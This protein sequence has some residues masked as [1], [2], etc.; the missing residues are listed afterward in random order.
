VAGCGI[1]RR[2]ASSC[3]PRAMDRPSEAQDQQIARWMRQGESRG[4]TLLMQHYGGRVAGF[5]R[6]RF[7]SFDE[8]A[9]H[10]VLA[11]AMLALADSFDPTRGS[12]AAW[13]LLLAHQRAVSRLRADRSE[14]QWESWTSDCEPAAA[15]ATPLEHLATHERLLEV[16]KIVR[17]LPA[18]EQ[19]VVEAD[20]EE[21]RAVSAQELATRLQTT[22]GSIYAARRRARQKLLARCPWINRM[23]QQ[24]KGPT[25]DPRASGG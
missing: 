10:D 4:F 8:Q 13:F 23:L 7:P 25:D 5:L 12:L 24:Q 21:G 1:D 15:D 3:H 22:A 18:L 11:D 17:S 16:E 9:I 6:Q 2:S 20:W 19:A 14:P